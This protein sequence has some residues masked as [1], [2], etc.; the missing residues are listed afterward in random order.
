MQASKTRQLIGGTRIVSVLMGFAWVALFLVLAIPVFIFSALGGVW[1]GRT[2]WEGLSPLCHGIIWI[3]GVL[4]VTWLIRVKANKRSLTSL[5]LPLPQF[6][7][8]VLGGLV[9][10]SLIMI[11]FLIEYELGWLHGVHFDTDLHLGV[12]RP[13]WMLLALV[14]SLAVGFS[15]ELVFRGY[16]FTTFGE[17]M[18]IWVAAIIMSVIFALFHFTLSGFNLAFVISVVAISFMFLSLRFAT[19]SLWFAIGLHGAWD[20]TQ[21]YVVGL[22]TTGSKHDPALVQISQAGPSFWVGGGQAIESGALFILIAFTVIACALVYAARVGK[23]P[24]W[25][26]R[27]S[28]EDA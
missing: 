27:L 22:S 4:L 19:G 7:R 3:G 5:G 18:P 20:W 17:R 14:P 11:A 1:L 16:I 9:G 6:T 8:L 26:Q 15:E 24:R 2:T 13:L 10:F 28:V 25:M 23:S 12:S 21:T